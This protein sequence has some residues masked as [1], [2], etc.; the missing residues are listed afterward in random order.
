[1]I[2]VLKLLT[3]KKSGISVT[4]RGDCQL[5]SDVILEVTDESLN[6]N[7]LRRLFGLA[8]YV[9][10]SIKTLDILAKFN[11]FNN[12]RH[13][14]KT[15]SNELLWLDKEKVYRLIY[16][17]N[18][19]KIVQFV[20]KLHRNNDIFLDLV[21]SIIRELIHMKRMDVVNDI[22]KLP[23]FKPLNFEYSELLF[24]G[25]SIGLLFNKKRVTHSDLLL[26]SNFIN[27]VY[28]IYVD[29]STLNGFYGDY[30]NLVL[31]NIKN[32]EIK[33]FAASILQLKNYLNLLPVNSN[34]SKKNLPINL[35]PILA[36][37]ILSIKLL[38]LKNEAFDKA[39]ND[40]IDAY[41]INRKIDIQFLYELTF[42]SILSKNFKL[43]KWIIFN[44]SK[45]IQHVPYYYK[46]HYE[47]FN[48]MC[49]FYYKWKKDVKALKYYEDNFQFD[50]L[51]YS[52]RNMLEV[53][54]I[55]FKY[56]SSEK[57]DA[58]L[59][60]YKLLTKKLSYPLFNKN[61][62]TNYFKA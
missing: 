23:R 57:K 20:N 59:A 11:G 25:N 17:S 26:N 21:I 37:R 51:K 46:H 43:M 45:K 60:E 50:D 8:P 30:T 27:C 48:F 12:Y 61:Y 29:Y 41:L 58:L 33:L 13:F 24:F 22:F 53:F 39:L 16:D 2:D 7:T 32:L 18:Q 40:F 10:P 35:H 49:L 55:V 44:F 56:D 19:N 34:F 6:Y 52:Y 42:T 28:L 3:E 1:M 31:A 38:V 15:N 4:N 9:K 14:L 47:L 5:L 36:G 62:L 54:Y